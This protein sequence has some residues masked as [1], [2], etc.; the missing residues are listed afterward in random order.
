M[1][2]RLC[3]GFLG[4]LLVVLADLKL[5][6]CLGILIR[7]VDGRGSAVGAWCWCCNSDCP[8]QPVSVWSF[9]NPIYGHSLGY[10]RRQ[11]TVQ[12][13]TSISTRVH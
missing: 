2:P 6:F 3:P 10:I 4:R 9:V 5:S 11:Y 1:S 13:K 7:N 12:I 8:T